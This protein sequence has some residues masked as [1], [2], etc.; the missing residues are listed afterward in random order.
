MNIAIIS[1]ANTRCGIGRYSAELSS[2]Y[3]GLHHDVTLYRKESGEE[4]YVVRYHHRSLKFLRH[5]I[6]PYYLK[7]AYSADHFDIVHADYVD[8]GS[9]F[10]NRTNTPLIATVHDAIPFMYPASGFAQYWYKRQLR[11]TA[12]KAYKLIVVSNT[13][14]QD[15]VKFTDIHPDQIV[16][17]HN[18]INHDFFYP[19]DEPAGND[20]FTIR[21]IGGLGGPYKNVKLLLET[22]EL[23][24]K[25]DINFKM[26][27]GGGYPEHT[28]L[29]EIAG[30][31]GLENVSFTG[32]IPDDDL[33]SFLAGADLFLYPSLYEGFGFPPLE[34]M[35]CGTAT[36]AANRGSLPEV[37][38]GGA[39]LAEPTAE[40]FAE[41]VTRIM[42]DTP[43]QKELEE[44]AVS[45][46]GK[47]T[48]DRCATETMELYEQAL[49][50]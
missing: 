6:A 10:S 14:K 4:D 50:K 1:C 42:N 31:L 41:Q 12:K 21:Y 3:N 7:K 23:L 29:P 32:F 37:L 18:G 35:A 40:K 2:K 17:V 15:L 9:T 16:A 22:A 24:E 47:Y 27:I 43:L 34:A 19:D 13:S 11:Q 39:L 33:R 28:E 8:A 45:T 44:K 38:E 20:L 36:V 25:Q 46:S 26:E 48:W 5:Y 30:K 49:K